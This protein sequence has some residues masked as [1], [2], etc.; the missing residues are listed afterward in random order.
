MYA[1]KTIIRAPLGKNEELRQVIAQKYLPVVRSRP[2]FMAAYLLE[3]VDDADTCELI[4]FWD[5]QA[6][7]ENFHRT[8]MLQASIQS[9]AAELPGVRLERQGYVV[10]VALGILPVEEDAVGV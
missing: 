3:Q 5:N 4:Q 2:G 7:L 6:A 8:G 1:Q 10:R 9:I